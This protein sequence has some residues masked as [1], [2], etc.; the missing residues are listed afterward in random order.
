[1]M[2][3]DPKKIFCGL[4]FQKDYCTFALQKKKNPIIMEE[5]SS[6]NKLFILM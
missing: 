2:A 3:K 4:D 1:M 5:G 6:R